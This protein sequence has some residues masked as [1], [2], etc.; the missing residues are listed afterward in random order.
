MRVRVSAVQFKQQPIAHFDDFARQ[1]TW[2]VQVAY[3]AGGQLLCFPEYV[4]GPLVGLPADVDRKGDA[5]DLSRWEDWTAS[6]IELFSGLAKQTGMYIVGGTHLTRVDQRWYNTAHL[7]DPDGG[8]HT[9]RKLHLTPYESDP[10]AL[11]AGETITVFDTPL[12]RIA[13]LICFDVEFPEAARAAVDAGAQI[14]L[15]PSATDDRAGFWR[16]RYCC[17]ARAVEN[18]VYVVHSALVGNLPTVRGL[19]QSYGRSAIISPCDIP[20]APD[21]IVA[22]GEWNQEL[23]ITGDIDLKLLDDVRSQGSVTPALC[24][25]SEYTARVMDLRALRG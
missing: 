14:L 24:R 16:V 11:D 9:Q 3:D 18:Q 17:F 19:E 4:T 7:F 5:N 15:C 12:G 21:G 10:W 8:I 13:I 2:A 6:Y 25:R 23:V 20:F 22:E 1:V